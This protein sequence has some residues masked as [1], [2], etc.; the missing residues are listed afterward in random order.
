MVDVQIFPSNTELPKFFYYQAIALGCAMWG[1]NDDY[2][3]DFTLAEPAQHIVVAQ[4]KRLISY[5]II[6]SVALEVAGI[7]YQC[8]GW[9]V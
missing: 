1:D 6:V 5:A 4:G 8:R 2:D 3:I 7:T 9:A